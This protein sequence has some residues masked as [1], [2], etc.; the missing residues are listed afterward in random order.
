MFIN[1]V[2]GLRMETNVDKHQI[3]LTEI[4]TSVNLGISFTSLK[5]ACDSNYL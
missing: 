3:L 4:K 2:R 1:K 5:V